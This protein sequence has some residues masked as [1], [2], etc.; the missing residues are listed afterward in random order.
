MTSRD[1]ANV[2]S[3]IETFLQLHGENDFK[4]K[5]YGRAART[6]ETSTFDMEGAVRSG[7]P[8]DIPGIGKA[9]AAEITEIVE[10][11]TTAQ[12]E[13]LRTATPPGLLDILQIRGLGAKKVRAIHQQLGVETLLELERA[14]IDGKIADLA[15]FG[16]KSQD[17]IIAGIRELAKNQSKFRI[18]IA[19]EIGERLL[20]A[21]EGL[22]S[23]GRAAIAGRLRRGAEEF[24]SL[25]F[26]VQSADPGS[27]SASLPIRGPCARLRADGVRITGITEEGLSGQIDIASPEQFRR[28]AA[29]AHRR[30]RLRL[31]DLDSAA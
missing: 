27:P 4:S 8:I 30:Q 16:K 17:K 3:D 26:V 13:E 15:G 20:A 5:A 28:A 31:H 23:A 22:P 21:L 18:N 14:A 11:G 12:L 7:M 29:S 9:L 24:D 19:T 1:V 6:L 2:F 10:T 25:S